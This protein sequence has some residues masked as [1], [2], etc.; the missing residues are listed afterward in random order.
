MAKAQKIDQPICQLDIPKRLVIRLREIW[1]VDGG[2]LDANDHQLDGLSRRKSFASNVPF[3]W[4]GRPGLP[5]VGWLV[6][7]WLA[8]SWLAGWF[9]ADWLAGSAGPE[10]AQ[11]RPRRGPEEARKSQG[12]SSR[13][14]PWAAVGSRG[15]P[16]AAVGGRGRP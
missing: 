7:G 6:P 3:L 12:S 16:W 1:I 5:A 15:H 8:G 2:T 11:K 14:R 10:E 9:L 13:G 4:I